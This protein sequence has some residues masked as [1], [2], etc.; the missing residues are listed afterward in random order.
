[1][2]DVVEALAGFTYARWVE[3]TGLVGSGKS[4]LADA[5]RELLSNAGTKAYSLREAELACFNRSWGGRTASRLS[6]KRMRA[7][8]AQAL[9]RWFVRPAFAS[10]FIF[11]H[12]ALISSVL[13]LMR[14]LAHLPAGHR[15]LIFQRFLAV[16]GAY[17]WIRPRL[18]ENELVILDEG[19]VHRAINLMAWQTHELDPRIVENYF[20]RLP[21]VDFLFVVDTP[22]QESLARAQQRGLP[23]RMRNKSQ[24]VISRFMDNSEIILDTACKFYITGKNGGAMISN[25]DAPQGADSQ[26]INTFENLLTVRMNPFTD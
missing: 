6:P 23:A 2:A 26:V 11:R 12:P 17:Q 16:A 5:A 18:M 24:R 22:V 15:W 21:A 10:I 25:Q 8:L 19:L 13:R 1:M 3:F 7:K 20:Q 14:G 4:T 9:L